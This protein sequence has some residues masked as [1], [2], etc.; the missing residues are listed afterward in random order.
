MEESVSTFQSAV[1]VDQCNGGFH[2][3]LPLAE[4]FN[5]DR[6]S[7]KE[8]GMYRSTK[9]RKLFE[10]CTISVRY[11]KME[12]EYGEVNPDK[13]VIRAGKKVYSPPLPSAYK[14]I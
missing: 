6:M 9:I 1:E 7:N 2:Q 8:Q 5:P 14:S 10:G 4:K 3:N 13:G 12:W 11:E